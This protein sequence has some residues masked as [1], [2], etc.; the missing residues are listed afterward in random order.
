MVNKA[1][2]VGFKGGDRPPGSAPECAACRKLICKC[3]AANKVGDH[4][5]CRLEKECK[6]MSVFISCIVLLT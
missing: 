5:N 3:T 2:F 1:T 6:I 4:Y